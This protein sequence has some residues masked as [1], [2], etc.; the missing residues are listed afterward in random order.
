MANVTLPTF[1]MLMNPIIQAL[2]TLG[3]SGTIEEINNKAIEIANL[4]DEQLHEATRDGA[5]AIDLMD[6]DQL[7]DK[8]K[9]PGLGVRTEIVQVEQI[10]VDQNW[11]LGI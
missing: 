7:I 3:G 6:G 2:N 5:P 8:L 9:E 11:L 4:S 1:E 10:I